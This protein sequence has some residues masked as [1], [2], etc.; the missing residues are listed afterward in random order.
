[1]SRIYIWA[2][3][4][5]LVA[6]LGGV[7]WPAAAAKPASPPGA[8]PAPAQDADLPLRITAATLEADQEKRLILFSG[9]VKAQ[10]GEAVLYCDQLYVYFQPPATPPPGPKAEPAPLPAGLG[11][12]EKIDRI[13]ARGRVRL[14][15][16]D[17]VATGETAIYYQDR[18]EIILTGNPKVWQGDNT[19]KGER[20]IVNTRENR[21]RVE[22][23]ASQRVEAFL[24]PQA[25]GTG[26]LLPAAPGRP[27]KDARPAP[28]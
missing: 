18:G 22:S 12:G 10:K 13:E 3:S 6:W 26:G 4:V 8:R 25:G 21:V 2:L 11:G 16:E 19:L 28:R 1:M 15:Y 20:I 23:S 24:Y 7:A 5:A 27:P 14:V 9:Q 17:R